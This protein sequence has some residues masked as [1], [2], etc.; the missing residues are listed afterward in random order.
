M[1]GTSADAIDI[2][3]IDTS[4]SDIKK[5]VY[6]NNFP[7]D[8]KLRGKILDLYTPSHN[9]IDRLGEI[10]NELGEALANCV[11]QTLTKLNLSSENI[12]AIGSHGQTIRHRPSENKCKAFTLQIGNGNILAERTGITTIT[13][14]RRRDMA[15][16]G[17]GAPL[18]PAL[19]RFAFA[20]DNVNRCVVNIGGI[21]NITHLPTKGPVTGF[22]CG[23]G[24]GLMDAWINQTKG[25][26]YDDNG[27]WA[28]KGSVDSNLL[29]ALL[30]D[31][32]V[33]TKPPKSTGREHFCLSWLRNKLEG[34]NISDND[35]QTTLLEF[36]AKTIT[37]HIEMFCANTTELYVC[38]GG[39][40]NAKLMQR[41]SEL[42]PNTRVLTTDALGIAP[43]DVEAITFAWLAMC[44]MEGMSG[45]LP[46][47]TG[48][49]KEAILG[50]IY[51]A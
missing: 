7:L 47:V 13:D 20:S 48:A 23:P 17:E 50:A 45:N 4:G 14:F 1:S 10:D 9:E 41:L 2:A 40:R 37:V 12:V 36:T 27:A 43:D 35:V 26:S 44:T 31:D 38:G 32:F 39:V 46:S 5:V 19:H 16:G 42:M 15:C 49:S 25:L 8:K 34:L 6:T 28:S 3:I 29:K 24:N 30:S 33:T 11:N 22:D 51:L 21:A 18:A